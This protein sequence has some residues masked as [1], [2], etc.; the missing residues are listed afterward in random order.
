MADEAKTVEFLDGEVYEK[1]MGRWSRVAGLKFLAWL[2]LS[3]G[4]R[5]LDVGCSTG[6]FAETIFSECKPREIV[7]VDPSEAQITFAL[8]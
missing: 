5:W 8:L 6:A 2:D 3:E 7:G 4:L 1:F